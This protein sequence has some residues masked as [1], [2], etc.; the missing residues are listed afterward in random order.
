[1]PCSVAVTFDYRCPFAYNAHAAVIRAVREGRTNVR[2][3]F[4]PFSLDQV[5][6]VEGEPPMWER[7]PD[8]WG[9][10][11]IALCYGLAVRDEFPE[12]FLDAHL[13]LFAIRHD[14]GGHLES[15]AELRVAIASVGLD[16]DAVGDVV[17]SGK[18]LATLAQEHTEAVERW[19]VFRRADLH[20]RRR[21]RVRPPDGARPHRQ[22]RPCPRPARMDSP[23][24]VQTDAHS[25]LTPR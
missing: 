1:V 7:S 3:R 8:S 2:F 25:A 17:A 16:A 13:A 21:G 24:R 9:T 4:T 10:G 15:E 14:R 11:V 22:P 5:H 20:R 23:Q 12:H 19:G 6:V 18:P